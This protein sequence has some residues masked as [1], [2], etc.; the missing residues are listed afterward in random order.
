MSTQYRSSSSSFPPSYNN[1]PYSV[2][3]DLSGGYHDNNYGLFPDDLNQLQDY[4]PD[5][6]TEDSSL[7]IFDGGDFNNP[8][9]SML[10]LGESNQSFDYPSPASTGG[11]DSGTDNDP[12][13]RNSSISSPDFT[14]YD[15]LHAA[16]S[17]RAIANHLESLSV[18]SPH[19]GMDN[20]PSSFSPP[21]F[22]QQPKA[23]PPRLQM[24]EGSQLGPGLTPAGGNTG[25]PTINAP[26]GDGLLGPQLHVVPAT[27]ITRHDGGNTQGQSLFHQPQVDSLGER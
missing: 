2:H 1:S 27:P 24:P 23:S 9:G 13:S 7:L 16:H 22:P 19:L 17:P 15:H 4:N 10:L 6:G 5:Y 18:N 26:D 25:L 20:L 8:S 12:R 21:F 3:S 11:G 14:N